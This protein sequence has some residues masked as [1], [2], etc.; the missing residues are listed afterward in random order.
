MQ[1]ISG[2]IKSRSVECVW[3]A[4]PCSSWT[5][6]RHGPTGSSWCTLRSNEHILGLPQ[7]QTH[8]KSAVS[9]GNH[10]MH[11]TLRL[12]NLCNSLCIMNFI[13]NPHSSRLWHSPGFKKLL[14]SPLCCTH[15]HDACQ[16]G[17]RWR[18]RTRVASHFAGTCAALQLK[19]QVRHGMC[20]LSG[21]PHIVL[22]GCDP[23]S[24][25]LWTK[26]AEPYPPK[27]CALYAKHINHVAMSD[28]IHALNR[29][30]GVV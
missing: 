13:E 19:C 10:F 6:A 12:I 4:T 3:I 29:L 16:Y 15:V 25:R 9:L 28:R 11:L 30:T 18:K 5:S 20:S 24:K 22:K 26:I 17:A 8:A 21:K 1:V 2:W 27:L 14:A 23:V 7:L